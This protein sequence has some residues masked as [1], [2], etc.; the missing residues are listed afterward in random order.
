MEAS[1]RRLSLSAVPVLALTA[2]V[3]PTRADALSLRFSWVGIP[4]CTSMSPAFELGGVPAGTKRLNFTMT[5]LVVRRGAIRYTGPCPPRGEHHNYRWTVQAL[6][7]AG[8]VLDRASAEAV[9]PP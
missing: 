9:F 4:A 7:A 1:M 8:K 6:D 2:A 3:L 5:D